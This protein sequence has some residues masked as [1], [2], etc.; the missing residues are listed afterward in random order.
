VPPASILCAR[1]N[2]KEA[3]EQIDVAIELAQAAVDRD[4]APG[5]SGARTAEAVTVCAGTVER[6]TPV[7]S[8]YQREV[9]R[10]LDRKDVGPVYY[11]TQLLGILKAL[12]GDI[13]AGYL[14]TF[15]EEVHA[16]VFA[17]FLDMADRL[18]A[19]G[20]VLPAAVVAGAA[21]EAHLRA[22]AERVGISTQAR[23]RPK[24][25]AALNDDLSKGDVYR[26]SE[27]K[28][29]LAWQDLRNS[30]AH[31]EGGFGREEIR[32]MIQG[33]RDFIGRHPA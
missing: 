31:G 4:F 26:K 23:G 30:A 29:V 18:V 22:L 8:V 16:D 20:Y 33:V 1:L 2:T 11:P 19:D 28:Q 10:A 27:Q 17:D 14:A 9:K 15:E 24:R 25:A 7:G 21:L 3:I 12:R 5:S 32:L 13:E 6:L